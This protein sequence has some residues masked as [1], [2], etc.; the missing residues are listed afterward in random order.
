MFL[1]IV[2]CSFLNWISNMSSNSSSSF[3]TSSNQSMLVPHPLVYFLTVG[4]LSPL[5]YQSY[6]LHYYQHPFHLSLSL[7]SSKQL[8][9][10]ELNKF[11]VVQYFL[12]NTEQTNLYNSFHITFVF[13]PLKP[14]S[15][16]IFFSS[17]ICSSVVFISVF[18]FVTFFS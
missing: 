18:H 13:C 11:Y 3:F 2:D 9:S 10:A 5:G 1:T 7:C 17:F 14:V 8:C 6:H 12:G 4:H 16:I 15:H